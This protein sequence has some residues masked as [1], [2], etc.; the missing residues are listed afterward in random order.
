MSFVNEGI[1]VNHL[2]DSQ[3][4]KS[5]LLKI[6]SLEN[7]K[8]LDDEIA[9]NTNKDIDLVAKKLTTILVGRQSGFLSEKASEIISDSQI[10]S[11]LL[12]GRVNLK[13]LKVLL[14]F[15]VDSRI[16][17]S[18]EEQI[19]NQVLPYTELVGLYFDIRNERAELKS[20]I[21]YM[22]DDIKREAL[23]VSERE[24]KIYKEVEEMKYNFSN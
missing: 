8:L 24:E 6:M 4:S 1:K 19:I 21:S 7:P 12:N 10:V 3:I 17:K 22:E 15:A 2:D 11:E 23:L 5:T 20:V 16:D 9:K 13:R 14:K 18:L